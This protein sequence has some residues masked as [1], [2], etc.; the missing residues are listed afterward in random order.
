MKITKNF[1]SSLNNAEIETCFDFNLG[2]TK[3][4]VH[5]NEEWNRSRE[6]S[7]AQI[8]IIPLTRVRILGTLITYCPFEAIEQEH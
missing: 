5:K 4:T 8:K 2:G 6:I 3:G 1:D 7:P